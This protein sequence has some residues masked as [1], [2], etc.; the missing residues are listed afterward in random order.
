MSHMIQSYINVVWAVLDILII[1]IWFKYGRKQFSDDNKR[2]FIHYSLLALCTSF[3]MQFAFYF[4]SDIHGYAAI[5]SSYASNAAMSILFLTD[6]LKRRNTKGQ[7]LTLAISKCV[8]TVAYFLYGNV[9]NG[10][11]IYILLMGIVC[12]VFDV[13]HIYF[14]FKFQSEST[15]QENSN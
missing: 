5:F 8:G 15:D 9:V 7:S 14:L 2:Y 13:L 1:V 10:V 3:I 11:H 4:C 6:L 12:Y